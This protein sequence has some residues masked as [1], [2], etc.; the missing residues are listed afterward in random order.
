MS[1]D[2]PRVPNFKRLLIG[3]AVIGIV[4][5][6]IVSVLGDD[7]QGYSETSAALYLGAFGAMFGL[8]L[9]ALLGITLDWSSRRSQ[10]RQ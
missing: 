3:G 9:A 10:S 7:A 5:G 6:V 2:T 8:A 1:P 4:I